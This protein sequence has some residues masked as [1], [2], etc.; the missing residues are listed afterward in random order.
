MVRWRHQS[1]KVTPIVLWKLFCLISCLL[2]ELCELPKWAI[3]LLDR[4]KHKWIRSKLSWPKTRWIDKYM[5]RTIVIDLVRFNIY[6]LSLQFMLNLVLF[7]RKIVKINNQIFVFVFLKLIC[8]LRLLS[9]RKIFGFVVD[10][11]DNRLHQ[12]SE[13]NNKLKAIKRAKNVF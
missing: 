9:F 5:Y 2:V 1:S 12:I 7:P 13:T 8:V 4:A 11:Y 10:K 6:V 3:K